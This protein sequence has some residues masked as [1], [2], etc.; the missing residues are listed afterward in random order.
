MQWCLSKLRL[1]KIT[2]ILKSYVFKNL[3]TWV[4]NNKTKL[5]AGKEFYI[6]L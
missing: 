4:S 3:K 5:Y 6:I 1:E 2:T